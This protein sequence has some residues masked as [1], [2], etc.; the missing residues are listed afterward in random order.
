LLLFSKRRA[1]LL[2]APAEFPHRTG[3]AVYMPAMTMVDGCIVAF[4]GAGLVAPGDL[5]PFQ[6]AGVS[7]VNP[8]AAVS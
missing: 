5:A 2:A 7:V 4:R 1:F 6:A 8:W 3:D